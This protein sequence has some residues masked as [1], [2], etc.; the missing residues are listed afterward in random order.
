ML[1]GRLFDLLSLFPLLNIGHILAN[2]QA[3]GNL[4][5]IILRF[6]IMVTAVAMGLGSL[7]CM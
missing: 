2:F 5:Q 6:I 3:V 1:I 4:L 7:L